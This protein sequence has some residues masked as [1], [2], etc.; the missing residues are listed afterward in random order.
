M[1]AGTP[2]SEEVKAAAMAA[3]LAGQSINQ[4][5][6]AYKL[7]RG[8]VGRWRAEISG[9]TRTA[10]GG[11]R[12]GRIGD[13]VLE[14]LEAMLKATTELIQFVSSEKD[15]LRD[16][17]ASEVA[18]LIGVISDKAYRILEALPDPEQQTADIPRVHTA[19]ESTF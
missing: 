9:E 1:A 8:T 17:S 3:M 6:K 19:G 2:H 10:L 13:L 15:W 12:A 11:E 14:N 18:V 7:P 16:Q 5:A 4:V